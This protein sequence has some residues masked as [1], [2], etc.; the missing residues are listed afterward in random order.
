MYR[1]TPGTR[2]PPEHASA[3]PDRPGSLVGASP[4]AYL[5]V[6]LVLSAALALIMRTVRWSERLVKRPLRGV[7]FGLAV[8]VVIAA[9][10]GLAKL[11]FDHQRCVDRST[12]IV[13]AAAD[14]QNAGSQVGGGYVWYYGGKGTQVGDP[15]QGGS[16][17]SPTGGG[18]G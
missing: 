12:P 6:F 17:T 13:V 16:L 3:R 2:T 10:F 5:L 15:V 7:R 1:N 8:V 11:R 4:R 9:Q 18:D 14:C